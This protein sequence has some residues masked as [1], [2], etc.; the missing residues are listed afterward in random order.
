M[1]TIF[2]ASTKV[3]IN[4]SF[5]M[6]ENEIEEKVSIMFT[7]FTCLSLFIEEFVISQISS[8]PLFSK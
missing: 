3:N 8:S 7:T 2:F 1:S 4:D 5:F 6:K